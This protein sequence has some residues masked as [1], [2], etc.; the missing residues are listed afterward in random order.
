MPVGPHYGTSE[1]YLLRGARR[2]PTLRLDREHASTTSNSQ[3]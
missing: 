3:I 2:K 1:T